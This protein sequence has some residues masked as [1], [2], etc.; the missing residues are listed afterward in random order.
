M[1][2]YR[3]GDKNNGKSLEKGL[4]VSGHCLTEKAEET[5]LKQPKAQAEET[6]KE[7]K[8]C[9]QNREGQERLRR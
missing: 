5:P 4:Q 6:D 3:H 9:R 8:A 1:H 7:D 2:I